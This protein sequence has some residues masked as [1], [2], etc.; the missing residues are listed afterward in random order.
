MADMFFTLDLEGVDWGD[1]ATYERLQQQLDE[2][3]VIFHLNNS[4]Q[5]EDIKTIDKNVKF[6]VISEEV[7]PTQTAIASVTAI[8]EFVKYVIITRGDM[9]DADSTPKQLVEAIPSHCSIKELYAWSDA[10]AFYYLLQK[11]LLEQHSSVLHLLQFVI[12]SNTGV[13]EVKNMHKNVRIVE[14][15]Q[16]IQATQNAIEAVQVIPEFVKYVIVY[17][18]DHINAYETP[19][20]VINAVPLACSKK[21]FL[22][23]M[24]NACKCSLLRECLLE[25]DA[26]LLKNAVQY[27]M[28]NRLMLQIGRN[29]TGV[30]G[31]V[32]KQDILRQHIAPFVGWHYSFSPGQICDGFYSRINERH[33]LRDKVLVFSKEEFSHRII[34][35]PMV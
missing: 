21:S 34:K 17:A 11:C 29:N 18:N 25:F 2:H 24:G 30:I 7:K 5:V 10:P 1:H 6:I 27:S 32:F 8:P 31:E 14:I 12:T 33:Q 3:H 4:T 26:E 20:Q 15:G 28:A 19:A 35:N 22:I 13:D 9:G 23:C 16:D